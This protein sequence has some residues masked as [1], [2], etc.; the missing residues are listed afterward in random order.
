MSDY[1]SLLYPFLDKHE[2]FQETPY[3]DNNGYETVGHGFNTDN[4]DVQGLLAAH[5]MDVD[6]L[7]SGEQSLDK[8]TSGQIRNSLIDKHANAIRQAL[9]SFD[10]LPPNKQAALVSKHYQ[11][12]ANFQE[13]APM[14]DDDSKQLDVMKT[15]TMQNAK[16]PGVLKRNLETAELY[17]GPLD[18]AS[19]FKTMTPDQKRQIAG[20]LDK[21]KNENTRKEVMDKINP[22]L[23]TVPQP[24]QFNRLNKML[25]ADL[26]KPEGQ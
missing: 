11:L 7:R 20:T 3:E 23:D 14:V 6:K 4:G 2:G 12:P 18:F 15:M 21:I 25:S 16:N 24:Q 8:D 5:G 13:L 22:Y 10:V 9:P 26:P 17:G 19:M 1:K